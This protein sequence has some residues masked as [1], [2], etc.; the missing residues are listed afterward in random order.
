MAME[1]LMLYLL[2]A[3]LYLFVLTTGYYFLMRR[4]A[5]PGFNRF[6][7]LGSFAFSLLLAAIPVIQVSDGGTSGSSGMIMLPEF[8]VDA[9]QESSRWSS[10]LVSQLQRTDILPFMVVM[11][12]GMVLM[13][14]IINLLRIFWL[15]RYNPVL[16]RDEMH[17]VLFNSPISPFSF[18]SYVFVPESILHKE[19]FSRVLAHEKAHY[20]KRHS[21]DILFM[22]TIQ[23]LFWYH[24]CFYY[25][26][27]ELKAQHEF[28]ADSFACRT[29]P[30]S[31]YQ[32][33]LLEY[34]LSGTMVPLTNPFNVSL[35]KKRIMMMNQAKKISRSGIMLK[36]LM[37]LP[38]LVLAVLVQSCQENVNESVNPMSEPTQ[39]SSTVKK[40]PVE[41]E[42]YT[43][44]EQNPSFP[45]GE[46]ARMKFMMNTLR[47]PNEARIA[48]V[49]GTVFV[50]FVITKEGKIANAKILRGVSPEVD[51]EALR[52]INMMPDWTPGVQRE[53][54][55]NVQFNMPIRFK[56]QDGE[57]KDSVTH[58]EYSSGTLKKIE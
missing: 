8:I 32:L 23:V 49:Q 3:S 52:V 2:R 39:E 9:S 33:T 28:E 30:K 14:S 55:V 53:E 4:T 1:N 58:W 36:T 7:I 50:T 34:T 41:G 29:V 15:T 25:L 6:F 51:A 18:F 24:P 38:F 27:K 10:G 54:A 42:I 16:R 12:S 13:I 57:D 46:E 40:T 45:G 47:Y 35:I 21:W 11:I 43:V 17:L 26:K 5:S 31:Q 48:G 22:E 56:L 19:H 44:V 37:L 20:K